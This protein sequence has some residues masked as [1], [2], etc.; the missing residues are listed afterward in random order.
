V[1]NDLENP[2]ISN[3]DPQLPTGPCQNPQLLYR[4]SPFATMKGQQSH[5]ESKFG[6]VGTAARLTINVIHSISKHEVTRPS[7]Y[8]ITIPTTAY[9]SEAIDIPKYKNYIGLKRNIL[10]KNDQKLIAWPFFEGEKE[11]PGTEA[12]YK[13]LKSGYTK[14]DPTDRHHHIFLRE[15]SKQ[16]APYLQRAVH[17]LGCT[18]SDV[19]RYLLEARPVL[20]IEMSPEDTEKWHDRHVHEVPE[21]FEGRDETWDTVL[22]RLPPSMDKALAMAGL[23]CV[24]FWVRLKFSFWH[25]VNLFFATRGVP[26]TFHGNVKKP[27]SVYTLL[28][29]RVCH[30]HDC[31]YHGEFKETVEGSEDGNEL[32]D[33]AFD[34]DYPGNVNH[35]ARVTVRSRPRLWKES[36]AY[37]KEPDVDIGQLLG[38]DD[39]GNVSGTWNNPAT[40]SGGEAGFPDSRICSEE[41][42][43]KKSNR[44]SD[45][46]QWSESE[47][48]LL[49]NL[50]PAYARSK[51]GA[52]ML[53]IAVDRPCVE[54][55]QVMLTIPVDSRSDRASPKLP[56]EEMNLKYWQE[57]KA[58]L[59]ENR[60]HFYPCSHE[61]SCEE[62]DCRCVIENIPC[63]ESCA[64]SLSC[65]RRFR[66]CSC[67]RVGQICR[68]NA[69]CECYLLN[70]EC[71]EHLC[72]KCGATEILNPMNRDQ[73][74][75]T[76]RRCA[77]VSI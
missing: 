51:R 71:S 35:K 38:I 13:E 7:T 28:A 75:I 32:A 31:F 44:T 16:W 58:Y 43:W 20:N 62:K 5:V 39:G 29:C 24:A 37:V 3:N 54:V 6:I 17:E 55:F 76:V 69:K 21:M 11:P 2:F 73:H 45:V 26:M 63:E 61:G 60:R 41:C 23:A 15:R 59:V 14:G 50:M 10:A 53:A 49:E 46:V 22:S 68:N 19:L 42:F 65:P 72:K 1:E 52:C 64:C 66:G 27:T 36:L 25:V 34:E 18:M 30:I 47:K 56:S 4:Q 8:F 33:N 48:Q 74:D 9:K 77:N 12:M 67:A 70:R 40:S 57:K